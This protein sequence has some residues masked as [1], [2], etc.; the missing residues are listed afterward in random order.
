MLVDVKNPKSINGKKKNHYLS[1]NACTGFVFFIDSQAAISALSSNSPTDCPSTVLTSHRW[2]KTARRKL[3]PCIWQMAP[4]IK[5]V[6]AMREIRCLLAKSRAESIHSTDTRAASDH[7]TAAGRTRSPAK[8]QGSAAAT[9]GGNVR[10]N[11][12][13]P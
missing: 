9:K 1:F 3:A 7:I 11:G 12:G 13:T 2:R 5:G 6:L 8:P 10:A 4:I